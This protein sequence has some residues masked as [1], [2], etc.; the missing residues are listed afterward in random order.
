MNA[1]IRQSRQNTQ[2]NSKA[3]KQVRK[4]ARGF[5][6]LDPE[7][8]TRDD[9]PQQD[10]DDVHAEVSSEF[11]ATSETLLTMPSTNDSTLA[12]LKIQLAFTRVIFARAEIHPFA[13]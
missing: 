10:V 3:E 5:S 6:Q 7:P 9:Q 11:F 1:E 13:T 12:S 4:I 8:R 2:Q